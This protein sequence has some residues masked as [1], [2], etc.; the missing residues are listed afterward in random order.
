MGY[1]NRSIKS[2]Q[3]ELSERTNNDAAD[4]RWIEFLLRNQPD[5]EDLQK[6]RL[7]LIAR[8]DPFA[9]LPKD[10][11]EEQAAEIAEQTAWLFGDSDTRPKITTLQELADAREKDFNRRYYG[12]AEGKA[13]W[14]YR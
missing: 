6:H 13:E 8:L 5:R 4:L 1:K 9:E 10:E 11:A 3:D 12:N 14:S 7:E 2:L